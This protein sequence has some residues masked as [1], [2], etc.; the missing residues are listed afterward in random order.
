M[1]KYQYATAANIEVLAIKLAQAAEIAKEAA[2]A[3]DQG[4]MNEAIG[5]LSMIEDDLSIARVLYDAARAL[6]RQ[7]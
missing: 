5:G 2:E 7:K 3:A 4:K 1:N 6:H